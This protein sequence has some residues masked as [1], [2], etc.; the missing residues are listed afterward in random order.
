LQLLG[1][2]CVP[3]STI[4]AGQDLALAVS[5][6]RLFSALDNGTNLVLSFTSVSSVLYDIQ[7]S[8]ALPSGAWANI[9]TNLS[10]TGGTI[11]HLSQLAPDFPACFFRLRPHF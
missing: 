1:L 3:G 4:D 2:N 11:A 5:P 6:A 9:A 10:G 8:P 7:S